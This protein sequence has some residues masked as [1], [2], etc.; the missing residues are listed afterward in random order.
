VRGLGA[1]GW[2]LGAFVPAITQVHTQSHAFSYIE[3]LR[4]SVSLFCENICG[5][6]WWR[7]RPPVCD[8]GCRARRAA[9][10]GRSLPSDRLLR[11]YPGCAVLLRRSEGDK[12][13]GEELRST[14]ERK[15]NV[16]FIIR[17]FGAAI[18]DAIGANAVD[19]PIIALDRQ[20]EGVAVEGI[21]GDGFEI[22]GDE[23]VE[24]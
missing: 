17:H 16:P 4:I 20:A 13:V 6:L 8:R 11:E 24:I 14:F 9:G 12:Q 3:I 19:D 18:V 10:V 7:G 1:G 21:G 5:D 15:G 22:C 2:D 23:V